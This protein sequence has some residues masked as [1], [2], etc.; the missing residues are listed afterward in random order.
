VSF[1]ITSSPWNKLLLG[2]IA[3][4]ML[5]AGL[6]LLREKLDHTINRPEEIENI[7]LLPN[8]AVIPQAAP[9]LLEAGANGDGHRTPLDPPGAEA[10]RV[11]RTNLL[12]SQ[13]SLKT[14]VVTSAAPGEGKTMTAVNLAAAVARQGLKVL[15]MECDLRRPSLTRYFDERS[16]VDL[17]DILLEGR[18]WREAIRPS[19]I[20]G[21]ALLLASRAVPRAAEFLAGAEMKEL[22]NQLSSQYDMV[23][24][25]TSP[26][27]VAADATILGAIADG[28]LLV[29]RTTHTDRSAI[30]Q[31]VQQLSLVGANIV[32]TVLND[33]E[34]AVAR[35]GT[36]Y[37][38]SAAYE[39]GE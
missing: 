9:Y 14:L 26:L 32:G 7:L 15:L 25:D 36:Y 39:G 17:S 16:G 21:L 31:A 3:G 20:P 33:P 12:F 22:L 35:Y 4:L 29:V 8:L 19:G 30:Q 13:G 27:L 37:D 18:A 28:V 24:L 1:P 6:A 11:L 34:G 23:I 2:L 10:Y 5:G 38:Y